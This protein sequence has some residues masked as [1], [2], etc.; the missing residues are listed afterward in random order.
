MLLLNKEHLAHQKDKLT[1]TVAKAED[2]ITAAA[3]ALCG[4]A[5]IAGREGDNRWD[6]WERCVEGSERASTFKCDR[7]AS[8]KLMM[9]S[10]LQTQHR[11]FN[12]YSGV[13]PVLCSASADDTHHFTCEFCSSPPEI[14]Q[15]RIPDPGIPVIIMTAIGSV[16]QTSVC[17]AISLSFIPSPVRCHLL[18]IKQQ[19]CWIMVKSAIVHCLQQQFTPELKSR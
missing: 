5:E 16:P 10:S 2:N 7:V 11:V 12:G 14:R 3:A 6:G 19:S 15:K 4:S 13:A 1:P 17:A 9:E 18:S 8:E